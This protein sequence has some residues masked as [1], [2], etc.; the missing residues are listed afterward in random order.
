M[1]LLTLAATWIVDKDLTVVVAI[2]L[3]SKPLVVAGLV[4]AVVDV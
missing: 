4:D 2:V 3:L 1:L